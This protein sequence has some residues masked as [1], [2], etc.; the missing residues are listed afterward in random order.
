M[1]TALLSYTTLWDRPP[2]AGTYNAI[3][4]Q[5]VATEVVGYCDDSRAA[6]VAARPATAS[7]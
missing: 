7:P 6:L 5:V 3:A 1:T 4:G 2:R